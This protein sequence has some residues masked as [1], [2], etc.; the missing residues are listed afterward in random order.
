M[1][2]TLDNPWGG[3]KY[4]VDIEVEEEIDFPQ[5]FKINSEVVK[6]KINAKKII[7]AALASACVSVAGW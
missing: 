6:M 1:D 5:D 7:V 2:K 4:N 3:G